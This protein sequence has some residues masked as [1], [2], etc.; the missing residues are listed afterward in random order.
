MTKQELRSKVRNAAQLHK[1]G[2]LTSQQAV[3]LCKDY[4]LQAT[5]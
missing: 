4:R 2:H 1:R 3:R 5:R